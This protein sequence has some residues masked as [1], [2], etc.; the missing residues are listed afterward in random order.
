MDSR[1]GNQ[2]LMPFHSMATQITG[3]HRATAAE[4][5]LEQGNWSLLIAMTFGAV[6]GFDSSAI[7]TFARL[8]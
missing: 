8:I 6:G 2:K 1:Q 7:V 3:Y 5:A 4:W